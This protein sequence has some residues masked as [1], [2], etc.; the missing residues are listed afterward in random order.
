MISSELISAIRNARRPLFIWGSGMRA[1]AKEAL[2]L[3]QSLGIPVACTW[4]ALDCIRNDHPLLAGGFGTHGTRAANLAVQNADLLISLGSRLD[5]KAT[6]NPAHFGRG[7]AIVM[8]DIDRAELD[9]MPCV[10][11]HIDWPICADVG[12]FLAALWSRLADAVENQM[13]R[14]EWVLKIQGWRR[15]YDDP[16]VT[17]P[18]VNPYHLMH[19]VAKYSTP[20]DIIVSDT[21][22]T[23]GWVMQ[24]FPFAG[25]RMIHDWNM[26]AMGYALPA[27]IGAHFAS[28]K[29]VICFVGDGSIMMSLPELATIARHNLPIKIILLSNG[30]H[31]MC[32]QTQRQWLGAKYPSTSV[33]GGL[34]FPDWREAFNSFRVYGGEYCKE[35]GGIEPLF[36]DGPTHCIVPIH[37]DAQLVPQARYGQP[38]EDA[39][40]QLPWEEFRQQ[41]IIE[42]L[43]RT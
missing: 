2:Q 7:A 6:G 12:E 1:Y 37:P 20:D 35:C 31:A 33:E 19:E 14:H 9:K 16:P 32:R 25:Q 18:G 27:A 36:D 10:G 3:A 28:G 17:W 15:L 41:M 8:V 30:G 21:G 40:P 29:R 4:G 39:D 24:A 5:T 42:P 43:E 11:R 26:T 23:I 13:S 22:C 38:I 34:G